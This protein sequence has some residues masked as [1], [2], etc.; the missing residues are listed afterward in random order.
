MP[1][2]TIA[3]LMKRGDEL[4]GIGDISGARLV[5]E[6]AA[7]G[8]SAKAMTALG[9]THDPGFLGRANARGIRPDPAIAAEWYRKA[10]ALGDAEA[11]A[12]MQQLSAVP[13]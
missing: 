12:R 11:A 1:A 4:I 9:M 6:R 3:A 10:A 5:Y 2:E 8:G 13:R 7:S